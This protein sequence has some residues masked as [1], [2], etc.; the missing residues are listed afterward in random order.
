M[1]QQA[2]IVFETELD[3]YKAEDIL[4]EGGSGR[5]YRVTAGGGEFAVKVLDP[6]RANTSKV[7]RFKNELNFGRR[8]RHDHIVPILDSGTVRLDGRNSPFFVMPKYGQSLRGL[9]AEGI[10]PSRV[11]KLYDGLLNAVAFAHGSAV[12]HRDLK[13]EN[14]LFDSATARL[15]LGDFGVAHFEEDDLITAVETRDAERLANFQYAAPEQRVKGGSVDH[16]ADIYALG[17]ILV[18]SFTGVVPHGTGYRR[19]GPVASK[20]AFV[21]EVAERMMRSDPADRYQSIG[22]VQRDLQLLSVGPALAKAR[23]VGAKVSANAE[24]ERLFRSSEGVSQMSQQVSDAY[25]HLAGVLG[26]LREESPVLKLEFERLGDEIVMR[27]PRAS[28]RVNWFHRYSNTLDEARVT[29][30]TYKW[31]LLLP[32]ERR[33]Y[34]NSMEPVNV[35]ESAFRPDFTVDRGACWIDESQHHLSAVELGDRLASEFLGIVETQETSD[36]ETE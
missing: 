34:R 21:D 8:V 26:R 2:R 24:K 22:A 16:R 11:L 27:T 6:G 5:V 18:E 10:E 14:V 29:I 31:R 4:G 15:L 7:K 3:T 20:Y 9:M 17:L 13:P 36:E 19:V 12:W 33:G 32:S 1:A 25:D 28:A 23:Q 35:G 30:W